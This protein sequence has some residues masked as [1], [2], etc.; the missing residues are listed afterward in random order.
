MIFVIK[1]QS[2]KRLVTHGEID[3]LSDQSWDFFLTI[4]EIFWASFEIVYGG[5]WST[6][7]VCRL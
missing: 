6:V 1:E 5:L 3:V 2:L 4:L 7:S